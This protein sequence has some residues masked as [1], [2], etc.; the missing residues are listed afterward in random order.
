MWVYAHML[1]IAFILVTPGTQNRGAV[2]KH[3]TDTGN[4]ENQTHT[5]GSAVQCITNCAMWASHV[6]ERDGGGGGS[7]SLIEMSQMS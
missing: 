1:C 2:I 6:S 4:S 7:D 3:A 5:T